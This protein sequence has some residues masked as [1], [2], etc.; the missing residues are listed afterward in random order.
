MSISWTISDFTFPN[1]F[2]TIN[3]T[4]AMRIMSDAN[5]LHATLS[6]ITVTFFCT[7]GMLMKATSISFHQYNTGVQKLKE[8]S[9]PM[10]QKILESQINSSK[11][12]IILSIMASIPLTFLSCMFFH[13]TYQ[14]MSGYYLIAYPGLKE[15]AQP[16][17]NK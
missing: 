3:P 5:T 10:L 11:K 7:L 2:S 4:T 13:L 12:S 15:I 14:S 1:D 16:L 17:L 6:L 8:A 9:T